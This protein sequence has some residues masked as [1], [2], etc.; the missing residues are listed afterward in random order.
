MIEKSRSANEK[1]N[2]ND[3]IVRQA[4]WE[5]H[6]GRCF[7]TGLQ[8]GDIK[9]MEV[10]HVLSE[11]LDTQPLE[12]K[13]RILR[14]YKLNQD[15]EL[16][17]LENFIPTTKYPNTL[18]SNKDY[19]LW[20]EAGLDKAKRMAPE[21]RKK[22]RGIEKKRN[23]DQN[24]ALVKSH[25]AGNYQEAE[26]LYDYLV[27]DDQEFSEEKYVNND[28]HS[29]IYHYS[30]S[31]ILLNA[32]L[33][34]FS[35]LGRGSCL[36]VF[37]T[38][39][40]R[41]CA[42]TFGHE[43]ILKTFCLNRNTKLHTNLRN[44]IICQ[45]NQDKKI[46][47]IQLGNARLPL[48]LETVE[49]MLEIVDDFASQYLDYLH[50]L[51]KHSGS[52]LF[53]PS[54]HGNGFRLFKIEKWL[55]SELM[56]FS[57][58]FDYDEGDSPWH[59]LD[60]RSNMFNVY[61]KTDTERFNAGHHATLYPEDVDG[62]SNEVW[63]TWA[64]LLRD[65]EQYKYDSSPFNSRDLWNANFTYSWL[66]DEL[67]PYTIYY[68]SLREG[69]LLNFLKRNLSTL[70]S[71]DKFLYYRF[72]KQ[73]EIEE[74]IRDGF[75]KGNYIDVEKICKKSDLL[76]IAYKLQFF[77]SIYNDQVS[78]GKGEFSS[79]LTSLCICIKYSQSKEWHYAR[80]KLSFVHGDCKED[81]IQDIQSFRETH[82]DQYFQSY[83]LDNIF[84]VFIDILEEN[85][86]NADE[87]EKV[88]AEW[89]PF[90]LFY[91][92]NLFIQKYIKGALVNDCISIS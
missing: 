88:L 9:Q 64:P 60:G 25:I 5:C 71:I 62:S 37:R 65:Y 23:Y 52:Y 26:K 61:M 10:D 82:E 4:I 45:D 81:I 1:V 22:I 47:Y 16:N 53:Q 11:N 14:K 55:W 87:V 85:H 89:M 36:I 56:R 28:G 41:N 44:F 86:L 32:F 31:N 66:V 30:K 80:E 77:F 17:S 13:Q 33:P 7:Y 43:E 27:D 74:Y 24:R 73:F 15:F 21:I 20:I 57:W 19:S 91:Q 38:L 59:I 72:L 75:V 58:R 8:I 40:L 50:T 69:G 46:Y 76:Q 34:A 48:E 78:F 68:F 42:I 35:N 51:N 3:D 6:R 70:H 12:E 67:I 49:A 79:L 90:I 84:R 63:V 54:E 29:A 92:E 2:K 39:K 18:K 83:M